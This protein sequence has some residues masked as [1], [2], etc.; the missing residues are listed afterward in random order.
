MIN[1]LI[2]FRCVLLVE[3]TG[4]LL[5][6]GAVLRVQE[7][8]CFYLHHSAPLL[9]SNQVLASDELSIVCC[10]EMRVGEHSD[11][12]RSAWPSPLAPS[13][14]WHAVLIIIVTTTPCLIG[15]L[16]PQSFRAELV[17]CLTPSAVACVKQP[18]NWQPIVRSAIDSKHHQLTAGLH[19]IL[20]QLLASHCY[21]IGLQNYYQCSNNT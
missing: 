12:T 9:R 1:V 13:P 3:H 5:A 10:H 20:N 16:D 21:E 4:L 14:G 8:L 7:S 18:Q 15:Y 6:H 2:L 11:C 17:P 19:A